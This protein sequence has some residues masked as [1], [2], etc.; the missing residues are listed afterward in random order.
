VP[1]A[2]R[3]DP[4]ADYLRGLIEVTGLS[5]REVAER[6]GIGFRLL[7]YYLTTPREGVESRVAPYPVQYALEMLAAEKA[8]GQ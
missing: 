7:K 4:S 6:I 5:Q 8:V 3:H 2:T 1:D